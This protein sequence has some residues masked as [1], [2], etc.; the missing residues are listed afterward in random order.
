MYY[1][2]HLKCKPV[3]N[4]NLGYKQQTI[5]KTHYQLHIKISML[6]GPA[7]IYASNGLLVLLGDLLLIPAAN[8][9][10][11]FHV[12]LYVLLVPYVFAIGSKF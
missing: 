2:K 11:F 3:H 7:L 1:L 10:I 5:F 4:S 8:S 12:L 9:M 6:G